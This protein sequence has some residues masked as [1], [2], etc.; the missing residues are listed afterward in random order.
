MGFES[1]GRLLI[2]MKTSTNRNWLHGIRVQPNSDPEPT[3]TG[4]ATPRCEDGWTAM[5]RWHQAQEHLYWLS[6]VYQRLT[7]DRLTLLF[8][9]LIILIDRWQ[10]EE[11]R[12]RIRSRRTTTV[13]SCS[14]KR[15]W[16]AT[17]KSGECVQVCTGVHRCALVPRR[18]SKSSSADKCR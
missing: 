1:Q 7:C 12:N 16:N 6:D 4:S 5:T 8:P 13:P 3:R 17:C 15:L 2:L 14:R 18:G 9:V 11:K 10:Q